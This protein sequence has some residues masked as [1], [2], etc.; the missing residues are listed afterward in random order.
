VHLRVLRAFVVEVSCCLA[1]LAAAQAATIEAGPEAAPGIRAIASLTAYDLGP[2]TIIR[3]HAG[4]Y[5]APIL[6]PL[7]GT[8]ESPITIEGDG[9][10]DINGSIVLEHAAFI[11]VRHLHI[12]HASDAGII[13]REGSHD[14]LVSGNI[15]EHTKLGIWLG[16]GVGAGIRILNNVI[17]F[18]TT[19]GIALD[20]VKGEPAGETVI[21]NNEIKDSGIHGIEIHA[22]SITIGGNKVSGSGRLSTG[23]S[24]I[25]VFAKDAEDGFGKHNIIDSNESFDNHDTSAQDGNGIQLDQWCDNNFVTANIIFNNDGAG[26]SVFD[27][28]GAII[29]G[30]TLRANMRDPG[31]SHRH[32][33]E[34]VFASDDEHNIDHTRRAKA[35]GNFI[36]A[37]NPEVAAILVDVPTSLHPPMFSNNSL[38]NTRNGPIARWAG[39]D[40]TSI[41][42]WNA[43]APHTEPDRVSKPKPG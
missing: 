2:G 14:I 25:H 29:T 15:I 10:I 43:L 13:L 23:A 35:G 40:I 28:A 22:N 9:P 31:R 41:T 19:H 27:A 6:V 5:T 32:K 34:L 39:R 16:D 24:G 30:N 21:G 18:S 8:E 33:G 37:A 11:T 42:A 17:S 3:L 12:V 1:C 36:I 26:I 38:Y 20:G 4:H 7:N